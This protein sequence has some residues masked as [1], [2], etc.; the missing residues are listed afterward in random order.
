MCKMRAGMKRGDA[1]KNVR[2]RTLLSLQKGGPPALFPI[3][4][5]CQSARYSA[6]KSTKKDCNEE[7]K[8]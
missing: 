8:S 2:H 4:D 7:L 5:I 3:L 6:T 1:I